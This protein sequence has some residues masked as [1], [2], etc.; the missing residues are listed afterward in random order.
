MNQ[1][2]IAFIIVGMTALGLGVQFYRR[3][4]AEPLARGLLKLGRVKWAMR[5]RGHSPLQGLGKGSCSS[6]KEC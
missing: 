2:P 5:V 3:T 4:L 1:E 6:C